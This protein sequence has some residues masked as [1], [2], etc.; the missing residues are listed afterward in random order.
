MNEVT[1]KKTVTKRDKQEIGKIGCPCC[2]ASEQSV[3]DDGRKCF[4]ICEHCEVQ[5]TWQRTK[6]RDRIRARFIEDQ[7]VIDDIPAE[8]ER[9]KNQPVS[10]LPDTVLSLAQEEQPTRKRKGLLFNFPIAFDEEE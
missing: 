5:T 4:M 9:I 3:I 1:E 2:Q 7:P 10:R 6:A 8:V